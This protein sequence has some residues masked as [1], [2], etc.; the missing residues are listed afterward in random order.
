MRLRNFAPNLSIKR[1][2][3]TTLRISV[4]TSSGSLDVVLPPSETETDQVQLEEAIEISGGMPIYQLVILCGLWG[5]AG[6]AMLVTVFMIEGLTAANLGDWVIKGNAS[7][8]AGCALGSFFTGILSDTQGRR[9]AVI[10][11][12]AV[13]SLGG[14]GSAWSCD[15]LTYLISRCLV[16][17]GAGGVMG[18]T[19]CLGIEAV[20]PR[21]RTWVTPAF[22]IAWSLGSLGMIVAALFVTQWR[23]LLNVVAIPSIVLLTAVVLKVPESPRWLLLQRGRVAAKTALERMANENSRQFTSNLAPV[24]TS[25]T[26]PVRVRDFLKGDLWVHTP[27]LTCVCFIA[28]MLYFGLSLG[29][30]ELVGNLHLNSALCF[31]AEIPALLLSGFFWDLL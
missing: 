21:Y 29:V 24:N 10:A 1:S 4:A 11:S 19:G 12:A 31:G 22:N 16:G 5:A 30:S 9:R 28:A 6:A 15:T 26:A 17:A 13:L 18:S 20:S 27:A 25:T 7:M 3:R 23:T 14:F 8:L 2:Q